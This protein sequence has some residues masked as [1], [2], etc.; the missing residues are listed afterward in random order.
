MKASAGGPV[1]ITKN[2]RPIAVLIG[3]QDEEEIERLLLAYS[4]RLRTILDL[5]R[6]QINEGGGMPHD[7]FWAEAVPPKAGKG[8]G[9]KGK[10]AK[11]GVPADKEERV[12]AEQA[13][14][15]DRPRE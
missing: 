4:P 5:S 13:A 14:A 7:E 15:A 6:K 9:K 8:K 12:R 3:V 10:T 2:G 1:V 11:A